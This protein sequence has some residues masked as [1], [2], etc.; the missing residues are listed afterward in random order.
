MHQI[1]EI[2]L[3]LVK[4]GL[5]NDQNFAILRNRGHSVEVTFENDS[6]VSIAMRNIPYSD[7]YNELTKARSFNLKM[8]DGALVQLMYEFLNDTLKNQRLAYFPSPYLEEFQN[9]PEIYQDDE[10]YANVVARNVVSFPVRFDYKEGNDSGQ[11]AA[12]PK[13]HL[14]L[15]QF[16]NC[17]IPVTAP[18]TPFR[19][20]DF[21]LRNFYHTASEQY[22]ENLP[23]SRGGTFPDSILPAER[24]V[25][26]VVVPAQSFRSK[27]RISTGAA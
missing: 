21:L 3:Y 22:A 9:N 8:L 4:A 18:L 26:H 20:V 27:S 15:G 12:H 17:R 1:N 2:I 14:T 13:S 10:V 24:T 19:F 23:D 5:A 25:V 11:S 16:R 7:I 6:N